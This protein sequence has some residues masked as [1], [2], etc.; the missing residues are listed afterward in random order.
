MIAGAVWLPCAVEMVEGV[1]T[2][3]EITGVGFAGNTVNDGTD[4]SNELMD[5]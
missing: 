1:E 5:W 4:C 2:V 3:E